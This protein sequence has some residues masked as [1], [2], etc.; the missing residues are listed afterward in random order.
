MQSTDIYITQRYKIKYGARKWPFCPLA[1]EWTNW[2][3][4]HSRISFMI[5]FDNLISY[6]PRYK[7]WVV[8]EYEINKGYMHE[9]LRWV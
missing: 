3:Y 8:Y 6:D 7:Q 5:N 1:G 2:Y 4:T 9:E